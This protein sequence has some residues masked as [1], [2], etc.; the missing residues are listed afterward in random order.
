M[1]IIP[2]RANRIAANLLHTFEADVLGNIRLIVL[3]GARLLVDADR[4]RTLAAD[5]PIGQAIDSTVGP[6]QFEDL[7]RLKRADVGGG[8]GHVGT[9]NRLSLPKRDQATLSD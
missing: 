2:R 8:I 9:L 3:P 4:A 1:A 7:I 5:R 6:G